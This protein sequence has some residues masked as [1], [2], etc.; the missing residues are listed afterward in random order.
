MK[1]VGI[2]GSNAA[3]SYNRL[4]LQFI[5]RHFAKNFH[6][7]ILEIDQVPMFDASFDQTDHPAIQLLNKE[8]LEADGVI[9]ATP[10][11]IHTIP[12][13]LKATVEWLSFKITPFIHKPV[14]A[15]GASHLE[16]GT[17][18]AQ[19]HMD[20]ILESPRVDAYVFPGN[21]FLLGRAKEKFDSEGNITDP[22][23]IAHLEKCMAKFIRYVN[24]I[25]HL[26]NIP[27]TTIE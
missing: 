2:V 4:L 15:I 13:A 25:N 6:L 1:L 21:E 18:R 10:E 27:E 3:F 23:T 14:Y 22:K 12:P 26:E 16:Q 11:H 8:I 19:I 17:S 5:K 9:I 24:L 7:E 20:Q